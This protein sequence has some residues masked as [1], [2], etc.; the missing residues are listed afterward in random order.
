MK[1]KSRKSIFAKSP[2]IIL[3]VS[4]TSVAA[5]CKFEDT[6]MESTIGSGEIFSFLQITSATGATIS[7]VATL[8]MKADI[9]PAKSDMKMMTWQ[10]FLHR[11]RIRSAR[12]FG[13]LDSIK[14]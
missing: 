10:T 2:S 6:A 1:K 9:A 7:T 11:S 12:R 3:V 14:K 8:S 5:P 13:I 4:P